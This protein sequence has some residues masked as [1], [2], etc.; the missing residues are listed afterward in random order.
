[1]NSKENYNILKINRCCVG[2]KASLEETDDTYCS[3]C[4]NKNN[5][6]S[7]IYKNK[8]RE[9]NICIRCTTAPAEI[10]KEHCRKCLEKCKIKHA[11]LRKKLKENNQC[12]TCTAKL[13]INDGLRCK[14]CDKRRNDLRKIQRAKDPLFKL[15]HSI[16]IIIAR[17]L[18]S[19]KSNKN[20]KARSQYLSFNAQELYNNINSKFEY[21][22]NW[23]NYGEYNPLIWEDD[24]PSTWTWQLD[25]II[26]RS[27]LSYSSVDDE[28]FKKCWALENLRPYSSKLNIIEG[29]QRTRHKK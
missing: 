3:K 11:A 1:M 26:P 14:K 22:M 7:H 16:S 13:E 29:A 19:K 28:N 25:H 9:K 12:I 6:S 24:D 2:C 17:M 18:R 27:E 8:L 5:I 20:G 15:M 23:N 4:R 21:W 10:G